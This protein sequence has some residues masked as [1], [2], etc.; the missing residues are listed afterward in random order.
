MQATFLLRIED[1]DFRGFDLRAASLPEGK[2]EIRLEAQNRKQILPIKT[3]LHP[4]RKL[5]HERSQEPTLLLSAHIPDELAADL[6]SAGVSHAD[7]NGR[8]FV[9]TPWFLLERSPTH[10]AY[11]N[12]T[13]GPDVFSHKTSRLVR[14][15]LSHRN[16]EWTQEDLRHHTGV[17]RGLV[18]RILT[19]L[20]GDELVQRSVAATRTTPARYRLAD[21]DRL[22]DQWKNADQWNERVTIQQV[23]LLS[24]SVPEIARTARDALGEKELV[25]TQWFAAHLRHPYTTPPVVSAYVKNERLLGVPLGRKVAT[26]GNLWLITPKD[27]GVFL[28]IQTVQGFQLACDVQIYLDLLQV[29]QRGPEQAEALRN[30]D[31]FAR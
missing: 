31:R 13:S 2:A 11:R 12:P 10:K 6:R 16:R 29:A 17:S 22:L 14:A 30:W 7:L 3:V 25:F 4:S 19:A 5:L 27:E 20:E 21:F 24:G 28:E 23:S 1:E 8:L 9:Q 26:G 15:F 18:S